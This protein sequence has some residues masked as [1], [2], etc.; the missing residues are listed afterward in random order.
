MN[1]L[2][3]DTALGGC[4]IAVITPRGHAMRQVET[5]RDQA[6]ILLPL[7]NDTL[8]EAGIDYADLDRIVTTTGPGSFTGLRLGLS[9]A[10]AL[11]LSLNKP[12][13]GVTTFD[14]IAAQF[15]TPVAVILE[16]KR[17]DFYAGLPGTP[18]MA[19]SADEIKKA[20]KDQKYPLAGDAIA[21]FMNEAGD[22]WADHHIGPQH[23]LILVD[24]LTLANL[25]ARRDITENITPL[26]LRGA[27]VSQPKTPPRHLAG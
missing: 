21:R 5:P 9:T 10:K 23:P 1:I 2:A 19:G 14:V 7:I 24:P 11:A 22:E 26:Y 15:N 18:P 16:T 20:F 13:V 3:F 6:K 8:A 4:S 25:G 12:L 17:S 27:D